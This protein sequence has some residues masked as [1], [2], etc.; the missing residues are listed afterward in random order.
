[1]TDRCSI[2]QASDDT[3]S[4]GFLAACGRKL[5]RSRSGQFLVAFLV[6]GLF[7]FLGWLALQEPYFS[8]LVL[9]A[10]AVGYG[11][12]RAWRILPISPATRA[13]W[14]E[15]EKIAQH[16]RAFHYRFLAPYAVASIGFHFLPGFSTRPWAPGEYAFHGFCFLVGALCQLLCRRFVRQIRARESTGEAPSGVV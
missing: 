9:A 10:L 1:M 13:R 8:S 4:S 2:D 6:A 3:E 11:L 16:S 15:D 14:V 7:I 12:D 5:G